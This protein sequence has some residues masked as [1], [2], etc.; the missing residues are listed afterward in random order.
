MKFQNIYLW[1][2]YAR[3]YQISSVNNTGGILGDWAVRPWFAAIRQP[4]QSLVGELEA[5]WVAK[6]YTSLG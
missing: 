5:I 1:V 4:R 6:L 3:P 2:M